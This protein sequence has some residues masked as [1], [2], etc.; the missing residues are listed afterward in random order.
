[1]TIDAED[2]TH[3]ICGGSTRPATKSHLPLGAYYCV[4]RPATKSHLP[5]GAYY[6]VGFRTALAGRLPR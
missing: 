3:G 5:L 6:C 1:M 4:G 2:I